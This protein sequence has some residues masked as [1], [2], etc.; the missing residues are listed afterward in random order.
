[1]CERTSSSAVL[2]GS[3]RALGS[4]YVLDL[5]SVNCRTGEKINDEQVQVARKEDALERSP[6]GARL[7]RARG[8]SVAALARHDTPLPSDHAIA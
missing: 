4:E 1:M 7:S 5:R 6:N 8:E 2:E 3:I